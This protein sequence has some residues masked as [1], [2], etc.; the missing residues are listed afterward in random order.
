MTDEA[1]KEARISPGTRILIGVVIGVAV[2]IFLGEYSTPIK[3]AG[4][5]Y[6]ALLQMTVLPYIVVSLISKIGGFTYERAKQVGRYGLSAQFAL[7][8]IAL[9]FVVLLPFSLP[10]WEAGTF[11]TSS[12][13]EE[14][15][16]FDF[17]DLY[18]PTNPFSSLANNIV[19]AAVV[20]S[21]LVGIALIPLAKKDRVLGPFEVIGDALGNI[22]HGVI[23][24][25]PYGTFALTAGAVG[26]SAPGEFIRLGGYLGTYT[27]G[28]VLLTF[29]LYPALVCSLTPIRYS[30]LLGRMRGTLGTAFATGKLF[31]VLP[32]IMED[33][34]SLLISQGLGDEEAE[35]T[36]NVLVPLAYPFPNAGKV[37][38]VVFIPFAAWYIGKPM[39]LVDY[40]LLVTVGL[41]S[42][43]GSPIVAIPFLL[44]LF[45]L[46]SDLLALFIVA[47]L[48][49][50]RFGDVLGVVHLSVFSLLTAARQHG[51]Y[52]LQ[53]RRALTWLVISVVA[54]GG[55]LWFNH[56]AVSWSLSDQEPPAHR[57]AAMKSYFE[58][59]GI[60]TVLA[61]GPNPSAREAGES[62]RQRIQRTGILRV[63]IP[64]GSPPFAYRNDAEQVVG[65]E[66]DLVHRLATELGVELQLVSLEPGQLEEAFAEDHFDLA[67]GG[68]ASV[69]RDATAY[70]ET[71]PYIE[72]HG[73][74]VVPDHDVDHFGS[75]N[76]IR[77]LGRLRVGYVEDG[78]LVRTGRHVLP[79]IEIVPL[80]TAEEFL[81]GEREDIDALFTT[82]ESG[83]IYTMMY[84]EFSVVVP[85]DM[86]VKVPIIFPVAADPDFTRIVDR[87]IQIKRVDGTVKLLHEHWILGRDQSTQD[88]R[89]SVAED[90]LGWGRN[91]P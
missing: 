7:W 14:P 65:L 15:A 55:A 62:V 35:D 38:A 25:A 85:E 22:S 41:L 26:M 4:D 77:R 32:M 19:P 82:A 61:P 87:F 84:P 71:R 34:K 56:V 46:P 40:P 39:D 70:E 5:V 33:V 24:L 23:R 67:V 12:L 27:V 8:G 37:L 75:E 11:F 50:A 57:V 43:F 79:G 16:E 59:A 13:V 30:E 80:A 72:L 86:H 90:V 48:W 47:G 42:F 74:V 66:I 20:F 44:G 89:W 53:K 52:R 60:E 88:K 36:T 68:H 63:G 81:A 18:I 9:G 91:S 64:P 6:L 83:A 10:D 2:G 58:G 3:V 76:S 78:V 49:G 51:W 21:I 1:V 17:L 73:A 28:I 31:A 45:R 54:V 69:V 29:I